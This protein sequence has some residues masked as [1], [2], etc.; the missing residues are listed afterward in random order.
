M[1]SYELVNQ[2]ADSRARR[3]RLLT[4]HGV[5]ETP[6]FMPVGTRGCVKGITPAQLA[7]TGAQIVLANTYH[8]VIR[9][10][11]EVVE[12]LGDLHGLMGWDGPILTDSGG[13]QVFSLSTLN[14]IGDDGVEFASHIDGAKIYLDPTVATQTQNRLGADVIMCFDECTPWPC[15]ADR[16]RKAVERTIR[17]AQQCKDTHANEKQRLF[18]IVQGGVDLELRSACAQKL[19]PMDFDGYAIGGLSVGEGHE[20]MIRTVEHTTAM[21][22]EDKPRYLMGVGMPVDIVE[23][24][25]AGVDMF[26]CVLPTRNGRNAYAFTNNGP[27]R[28]R[29]SQYVKD[30][31]PI[32]TDCPCYACQNFGK[33][34]LRH[35]FNVGEML[36]PILVSIHNLTYYQRLTNEIR[37]QIENKTYNEWADAFCGKHKG[38]A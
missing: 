33:G 16:L 37:T 12:S 25:R 20:H 24:V 1:K 21:L 23:A 2:D 38:E 35:F 6:V 9:P 11:T 8:M 18:G 31:G 26:D 4:A 34:T 27:I 17:W 22:P 29:N 14:R 3:G 7:T 36:G 19:I 5:V 28:L 32:E 13:Y 30:A 15:P 10:G